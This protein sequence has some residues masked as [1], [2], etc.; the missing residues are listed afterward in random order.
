MEEGCCLGQMW[1]QSS[2]QHLADAKPTHADLELG[3]DRAAA[4]L[5]ELVAK[6]EAWLPASGAGVADLARLAVD[7]AEGSAIRGMCALA[8]VHSV[9]IQGL[10]LATS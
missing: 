10:Y 5:V 1:G 3:V 6:K 7:D 2:F 9:M 4:R 8:A